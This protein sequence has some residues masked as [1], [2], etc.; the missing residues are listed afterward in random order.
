MSNISSR[1]LV[2]TSVLSLRERSRICLR[3]LLVFLCDSL[4]YPSER[5]SEAA[6]HRGEN[7]GS[8]RRIDK[9][10]I[11]QTP[12]GGPAAPQQRLSSAPA[13]AQQRPS[14]TPPT[15]EAPEPTNTP[16]DTIIPPAPL[17]DIIIIRRVFVGSG[18]SGV[19]AAGALLG[20]CWGAAEALPGRCWAPLGRLGDPHLVNSPK[21]AS[22]LIPVHLHARVRSRI[23]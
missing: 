18:A 20:C 15:P 1:L 17:G 3:T 19:G 8:F 14:S 11:P 9:V 21:T 6:S 2:G 13:A 10:R 23:F 22:V 7:R 4:R 5:L 16:L 12:Q